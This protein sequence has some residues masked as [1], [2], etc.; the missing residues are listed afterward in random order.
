MTSHSTTFTVTRSGARLLLAALLSTAAGCGGG[1]PQAE[2]VERPATS[3]QTPATAPGAKGTGGAARETVSSSLVDRSRPQLAFTDRARPPAPAIQAFLAESDAANHGWMSEVVQKQGREALMVLLEGVLAGQGPATNAGLAPEFSTTTLRPELVTAYT[4]G[5]KSVSRPA[6]LDPERLR[7]GAAGAALRDLH[8]PFAGASKPRAEVEIVASSSP[9]EGRFVTEA[10]IVLSG[11]LD[12]RR[13]Q[14]STTWRT[15]WLERP[16]AAPLLED[17]EVLAYEE[18]SF[19]RALFGDL[20]AHAFGAHPFFRAEFLLGVDDYYFRIDRLAGAAF[21]GSQGVAVGDVNG[22]GLDDI[23]AAQQGGFPNRLFLHRPDGRGEDISRGSGVG[24]LDPVRS[25]LFV[26]LDNDGDQDLA[27]ALGANILVVYNGGQGLF[28]APVLLEGGEQ[29]NVFSMCAA[30]PDNDGDLDIYACHYVLSTDGESTLPAPYYDANNGSRNHYWRNDG[31]GKFT[32]ATEEVGLDVNNE[33]FTLAAIWEDLDLD[34]DVDLYVTNDFGRNNLFRNDGGHFVDVAEE[35]GAIDMA[36][37]MGATAADYDRDGDMDIYVSNMFMAE[38][39]RIVP[40]SD[41]FRKGKD[42]DV[43]PSYKQ[44]SSGNTL[45]RNRGDGTFENATMEAGVSRGGWAWGAMFADFNND[46]WPDIYV[47]NGFI[48]GW[49]EEDVDSF[50]W[51]SVTSRAPLGGYMTQEY[52]MAWAALEY[53]V[54]QKGASWSGHERNRVYLNTRDGR[55]ADVGAASGIDFLEDSRSACMVDWDDDG[56]LDMVM[57]NRTAPR[58]RLLLNQDESG[59]SFLAV[60]L[61][62]TT[63]NRDAIGARVEVEVEGVTLRRTLYAGEG[64]IAQSSKRLHFGLGPAETVRSLTVY[65]PGGTSDR[66]EG[67]AVNSRYRITQGADEPELIPAREAV[68]LASKVTRPLTQPVDSRVD[69]VVLVDRLPIGPLRVPSFKNR[70]RT[71]ADFEGFSVL[72]DVF[73][74][75]SED[76][77]KELGRFQRRRAQ[78]KEAGIYVI[79]LSVDEPE[80]LDAAQ[81]LL[82]QYGLRPLAGVLDERAE[83]AF[84]VL[85]S[86]VLGRSSTTPL[87]TSFLVDQHGNL[88]VVYLG[89]VRVPQLLSDVA[90]LKQIPPHQLSGQ[91]L[92][93]AQ[94]LTPRQRDLSRIVDAL[95]KLGL[96]DLGRHFFEFEQQ[97][98][99]AE[100]QGER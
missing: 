57:K 85:L 42:L 28:M 18:V 58:L 81:E 93:G 31:V 65:W 52:T 78:L 17:I 84:E 3:G 9:A 53:M 46:G 32:D 54:M 15:G 50:H 14:V 5:A 95:G 88:S 27:L 4:D 40:H 82:D 36:A 33:R 25:A 41:L 67:L 68:D 38:G 49:T 79:P 1:E 22:D 98:V 66:H 45:L 87:P 80:D 61:A 11:V 86:D 90:V 13:V 21:I 20:T 59:G 47:P 30:D 10:L 62:G 92:L 100:H 75:Y 91:A 97:R 6:Q 19:P 72:F 16:D 51:R 7:G 99:A 55:F 35:S 12:G 60:E 76:C 39:L 71:V 89:P 24:F 56:R 74:S 64:F 26:D 29:N 83:F 34:G 44:F 23:Y 8:A 77:H 63:C 70:D 69:R 43:H 96:R 73:A 48:T 2:S 37:G 94:W